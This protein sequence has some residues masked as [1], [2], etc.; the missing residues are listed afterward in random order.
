VAEYLADLKGV[1]LDTLAAATTQNF[2]ALFQ[3]H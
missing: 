1:P 2:R 3:V